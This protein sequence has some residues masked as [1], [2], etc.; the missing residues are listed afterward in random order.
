MY[1]IH[2]RNFSIT[3]Y[4]IFFY[5]ISIILIPI[6]FAVFKRIVKFYRTQFTYNEILFPRD[7]SL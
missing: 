5:L 6:N 7:H 4:K 1:N 2:Y 3:T